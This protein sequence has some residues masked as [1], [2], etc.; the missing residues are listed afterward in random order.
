VFHLVL[1]NVPEP[2]RD[3]GSAK[4]SAGKEV[5]SANAARLDR[6]ESLDES[7]PRASRSSSAAL[8]VRERFHLLDFHVKQVTNSSAL[9]RARIFNVGSVNVI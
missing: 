8:R 1:S 2:K 7:A 5:S 9:I 4:S 6:S 3:A